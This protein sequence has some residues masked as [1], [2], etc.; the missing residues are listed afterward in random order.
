MVFSVIPLALAEVKAAFVW[1]LL[2]FLILFAKQ[3]VTQPFRALSTLVIGASLI[4]GLAWTYQMT[5]QAAG[6][7]STMQEVYDRQIRY[8]FDPDEYRADMKRL[9]RMTAIVYWWQRHSLAKDPVTTLFGHGIGASRSTSSLAVGELARKLP[10]PVDVNAASVLL[11][12]VGLLGAAAFFA[13]LAVAALA[14]LRLSQNQ[15]L[16]A[17]W[18]E[19]CLFSACVLALATSSLLYN[20]DTIDNAVVQTLIYFSIGQALLARRALLAI[21]TRHS[22]PAQKGPRSVPGAAPGAMY[23]H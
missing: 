13:L 14:A 6:G 15:E 9:G 5:Y 16:S 12:D 22:G 10:V 18:R 19:S 8:T 7:G 21:R 23:S 11:W 2:I 3:F 20:R 17:T 1:L 4:G